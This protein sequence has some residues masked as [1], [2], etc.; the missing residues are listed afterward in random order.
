MANNYFK[1]YT[2]WYNVYIFDA[3]N[4]KFVHITHEVANYTSWKIIFDNAAGIRKAAG[5]IYYQVLYFENE[6]DK[7]VHLSVW[8]S[9]ENA[10]R[11]FESPELVSI[12]ERAGVKSPEFLYLEELE[13][14]IL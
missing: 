13:S 12:R 11:F 2:D 9:H 3:V 8:S 14:G 7:I 6:P 4:L 5:E 1:Y 10:R